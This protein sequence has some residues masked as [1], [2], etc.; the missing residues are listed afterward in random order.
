MKKKAEKS[1]GGQLFD[2][3]R[4]GGQLF[5]CHSRKTTTVYNLK[6]QDKNQLVNFWLSK[7]QLFGKPSFCKLGQVVIFSSIKGSLIRLTNTVYY[8]IN[9]PASEGSDL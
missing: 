4:A 5:D 9:L 3:Q 8:Q 1:A 6:N 2:C 7:G